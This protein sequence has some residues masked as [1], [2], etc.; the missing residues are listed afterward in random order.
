MTPKRTGADATGHGW[1]GAPA[2]RYRPGV[3]VDAVAAV[4]GRG[5][6]VRRV[7]LLV[8]ALVA[9]YLFIPTLGQVLSAWPRLAHLN[10][11]WLAVAV[12]A[13]AGS[14]VCVWWL[15]ALALRASSWFAIATS[16]LAGNALSR[17][18]PA[19]A[20]AGAALQYRMLAASGID[21][22][23]AGSALTAVTLMQLATLAAIPVLGLLFSLTGR[24]LN[25]G[26]QAAAWVGLGAFVAL[27]VVGAVL[28]SSDR[29]VAWIGAAIQWVRNRARRH[30][31]PLTGLPDELLA[32]RDTVRRALGQRWGSALLASVGKWA[33]DYFALLACLAAVGA[34][35]DPGLVLL[36]YA[37]GAVLVMIPITPGGLGF[38]E[39][40]LTGVLTIAGVAPGDAVL[41]TLAYRLVSFW[42]PL[43][44]GLGAYAV[45][46]RRNRRPLPAA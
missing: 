6:I 7:V 32:E 28:S 8:G 21:A 20:A 25:H 36:A 37:A 5:R 43:P 44:T 9:L 41:A 42:L 17:A 34:R 1:A 26:L 11:L 38:V 13:E 12:G 45:F 35:P 46:R 31:P 15:L 3:G 24:P 23:A 30:H 19:G 27:V 29:A 16:Q 2:T 14:F 40:G 10:L 4:P 39:A 33:F 18:V 22:T